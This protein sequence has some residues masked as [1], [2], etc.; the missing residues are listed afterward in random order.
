MDVAED[1]PER[2][3]GVE[4]FELGLRARYRVRLGGAVDL[5]AGEIGRAG[6]G[7]RIVERVDEDRVLQVAHGRVDVLDVGDLAARSLVALDPDAGRDGAL[8]A[9]RVLAV[10]EVIFDQDVLEPVGGLA[11]DRDA[12]R[13]IALVVADRDMG[14]GGVVGLHGH[15]VVA[16]LDNGVVDRAV[17]RRVEVDAVGVER[18]I[19]GVDVQPPDDEAAAVLEVQVLLGRVGQ[20]QVVDGQV[21]GVGGLDQPRVDLLQ[22][23]RGRGRR[24]LPPGGVGAEDG[25]VAAAVDGAL[26][27]PARAWRALTLDTRVDPGD[28]DERVAAVAGGADRTAGGVAGDLVVGRLPRGVERHSGPDDQVLVVA[29]SERAGQEPGVRPIRGQDHG[30]PGACAE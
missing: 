7:G 16:V 19:Q 4:A 27:V 1:Q 13:A 6:P 2:I 15:A 5:D 18:G 9:G 20:R 17:G 25:Q 22:P 10:D 30:L 3:G 29:D 28:R 26:V 11:A 23:L 14:V 12:V 24:H 8:R 21:V